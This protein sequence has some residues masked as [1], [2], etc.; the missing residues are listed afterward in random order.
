MKYITIYL[1]SLITSNNIALSFLPQGS[2]IKPDDPDETDFLS[3]NPNLIWGILI[4][5]FLI[6]FIGYLIYSSKKKKERED[7]K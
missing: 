6:T 7:N 1:F 3:S 5:V 4:G 2:L